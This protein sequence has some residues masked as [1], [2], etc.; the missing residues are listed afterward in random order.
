MNYTETNI[1]GVWI[2]EPKV[3]PDARGY[4]MEAFKQSDFE[5]HIGPT[6]FI[7]DNESCSARE[8]AIFTYK[9]DNPYMPT[10]ERGFRFDDPA[11]GIQWG[12]ED[13][14]SV[15]TSKKDCVMPL[16]RDAEMNFVF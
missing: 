3:F 1:P 2:I 8:T 16:M 15:I 6:H 9:I 12:I 7:Q 13:K 4:F 10:H 5:Q 14:A 11:V